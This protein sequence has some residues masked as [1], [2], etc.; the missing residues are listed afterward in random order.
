MST[1]QVRVPHGLGVEGAKT[2]LNSF[3]AD[4]AKRGAKLVWAGAQ[5]EVRGPGV[6]GGVSVT[7]AAVE[8]S[9]KLGLLAKAAGVKADK[10]EASISKRLHAALGSSA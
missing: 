2:A 10:L 7:E 6:S 3:E 1:V 8:V 5:A 9:I 4:L